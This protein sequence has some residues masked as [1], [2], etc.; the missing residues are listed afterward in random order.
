L[1]LSELYVDKKKEEL[2]ESIEDLSFIK[3]D[4]AECNEILSKIQN[5]ITTQ[6]QRETE[7][8][9][10]IKAADQELKE[11]RKTIEDYE[12]QIERLK[13]QKATASRGIKEEV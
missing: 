2:D 6:H 1:F 10:L 12:Q 9:K 13:K 5:N 8:V 11:K 4:I 7:Y 3:K